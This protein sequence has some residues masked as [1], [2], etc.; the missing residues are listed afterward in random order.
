[1]NG[2]REKFKNKRTR[3]IAYAV[4]IATMVGWVTY[5]FVAIYR[6]NN[7]FVYNAVRN[8]IEQ[9]LPVETITV[10][11]KNDVLREPIMIKNNRGY[12][13]S[14]R[15][16]R[17]AAGQKI[18]DGRITSVSNSID[19]DTGMH[20]VRTSGVADGLQYALH[21]AHGFFVPVYAVKNGTVMVARDNI[22]RSVSVNVARADADNALITS[23]LADGD[24]VILSDVNDGARIKINQ[25]K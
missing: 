9:G 10:T 3:H 6:E 1:M 15:V 4:L 22:A 16:G 18:G 17:I 19:L 14:S 2:L 11:E 5:R 25:S 20:V 24:V 8:A 7:L 23:G 13:A 21:N 12:I